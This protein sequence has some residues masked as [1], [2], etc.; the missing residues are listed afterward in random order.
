[1]PHAAKSV[2]IVDD[3]R[4]YVD[5]LSATLSERF[6]NPIVTFTRPLAALEALPHLDV[7]VI[8]TD[9]YMP[10][11]N[12]LDFIVR[13]RAIKPGVPF[14][15]IT[16]HA[17]HFSSDDFPHVP[18]L[19]SVLHK[20]FGWRTLADEIVHVWPADDVITLKQNALLE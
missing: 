14:I 4:S 20:P 17:A 1:M 11:L 5:L 7:G 9:Y 16:G 8:V 18:E 19:R 15:I 3:E 13:A 2:L 12:G 10:Q 6:A